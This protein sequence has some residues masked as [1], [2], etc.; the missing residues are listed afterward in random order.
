MAQY[1]RPHFRAGAQEVHVV[2]DNPGAM[3]ETPKK[4]EQ[5]RNAITKE[6][7]QKQT[8]MQK[9]TRVAHDCKE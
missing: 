9:K 8:T 6:I 1:V 2:F 5:K 7:E 4:I 3:K